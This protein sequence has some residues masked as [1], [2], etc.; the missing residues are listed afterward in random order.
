[1]QHFLTT[2]PTTLADWKEQNTKRTVPAGDNTPFAVLLLARKFD[3]PWLLTSVMYCI[4]SPPQKTLGGV[5]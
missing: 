1:M 4:C 5:S 3:L 2:Y